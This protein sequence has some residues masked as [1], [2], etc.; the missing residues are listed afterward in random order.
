M[1][2]HHA[3][4]TLSHPGSR[5]Q[6]GGQRDMHSIAVHAVSDLLVNR[7]ASQLAHCRVLENLVLR[8]G[9]FGGPEP[10]WLGWLQPLLLPTKTE[11]HFNFLSF[12]VTYLL[13]N[14]P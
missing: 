8:S 10:K 3:G 12:C 11:T 6:R 5:N 2:D 14:I 4:E 9:S 7:L 13:G 1:S